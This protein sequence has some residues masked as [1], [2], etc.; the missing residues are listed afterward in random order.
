MGMPWSSGYCAL[1]LKGLVS[2]DI[3][4]ASEK[5]M[6]FWSKDGR[7]FLSAMLRASASSV[8]TKLP[9]AMALQLLLDTS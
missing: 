6:G 1:P 8:R 2:L 7:P 5:D 9:S 3:A 4:D